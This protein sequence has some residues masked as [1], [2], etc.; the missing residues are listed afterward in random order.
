MNP[1]HMRLGTRGSAK[2]ASTCNEN[3]RSA[4]EF[5]H[6]MGCQLVLA[7]GPRKLEELP[8]L[9][10][11]QEWPSMRNILKALERKGRGCVFTKIDWPDAY[12]HILMNP[13]DQR[14]QVIRWAGR[15]FVVLYLT[16][17]C[18]SSPGNYDL[19]LA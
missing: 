3:Y 2:L 9:V 4:Y 12:K 13:E 1:Y 8:W 19:I 17:G 5:G 6:L 15:Y 14:L 7:I 11:H 16:F 10:K 18:K